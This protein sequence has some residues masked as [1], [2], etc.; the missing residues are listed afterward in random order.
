MAL[1]VPSSGTD[2]AGHPAARRRGLA[3]PVLVVL[4]AVVLAALVAAGTI[5]A[6]HGSAPSSTAD[7]PGPR[8]SPT[9]AADATPD[10]AEQRV[11]ALTTL[12]DARS[13]AVLGHDKSAWLAT[14]DPE[15]TTFRAEQAKVFDNL[16]DVPFSQWSYQFAGVAPA[17]DADR[18][19][20][21]GPDAWVAHVIAGYRLRGF[22]VAT[23]QTDQ[24]F[25]VVQRDG[26]WLLAA[27]SDGDTLSQP[28]DLGPIQVVHGDRVLA[29]GTATNA[30]LRRYAKAGD[31][32]V[33]RVS[34]VWGADWPRKAVLVVPK[35]QKEMGALL[36]RSS[37]G[38]SQIAAV[39]TGELADGDH[40]VAGADRVVIN[41]SA[42][43]RLG[44]MG[45]R[46]VLTHEMTHVAVRSSTSAPV[47]SWL[48]EGF[49]D[50]VGYRT[51]ELSRRTI[52]ADVLDLVRHGHGPKALP[53][54]DDFDPTKTTI[55]PAYSGSWL[56]ISLLVDRYGRSAVVDLYRTAA[57][58]PVGEAGPDPDAALA[59]AF[60]SVLGTSVAAFTRDWLAYL[61]SLAG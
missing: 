55:A 48:S 20:T 61:T 32:A 1:P 53:T 30:T 31:A 7:E 23:S 54:T 10:P 46:V 49:A 38:L 21:L 41:P 17:P 37:K 56:A 42:F 8:T 36:D 47:P 14:V 52:A 3:R 45:R 13:A 24:F 34:A 19:K 11:T 18:M 5:L 60:T 2:L 58:T 39:T 6:L 35:T 43:D 12:L 25:P 29:M 22:D 44:T 15:S 27:D 16:A 26:S 51:V 57:T 4:A 59:K 33:R 50:Y 28:W 40:G 9:A